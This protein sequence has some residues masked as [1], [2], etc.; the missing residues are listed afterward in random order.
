MTRLSAETLNALPQSV[1]APAYDRQAVT[2]GIVHLGIGAFHRAHMASYVD[3]C[4]PDDPRWGI[5]GVSLRSSATKNALGPQDGLYTLGVQSSQGLT[6]RII[7][8]VKDLI[9]APESPESVAERLS[10]PAIRIV[11]LTVTEKGYCHDPATGRLNA[12]HPDIA[13]DL[14]TANFPRT[15]V[16]W[17]AHGLLARK[18]ASIAPFTILSC[19]N[20]PSNGQTVRQVLADFLEHKAPD[21]VDWFASEVT[22]PSTMV[23]RI[24]PATTDEDRVAV[25]R[26]LGVQDAW[27]VITEPFTQFVVEDHFTLGRPNWEAHGVTMAED[28]EPFERMKLRMLNGS[29]STL[30]Y[31]GYLAGDETVA[32]TMADPSFKRLIG[33]LM[34]EEIK[35]T[36]SMPPEVD[37]IAYRDA[38]LERFSN[39]ALK[40]RTWQIAMD[41]SQKLPQRLLGTI[42]DRLDSGQSFDR[43]ALGVA[44]WM[45][46]ALGADE[47]GNA[48]DVRDP[49][50][51]DFAKIPSTN[52]VETVQA[53]LGIMQIFGTDLPNEPAFV[54]TVTDKFAQLQQDGARATISAHA[55]D[56]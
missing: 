44:A 54:R 36:L 51:D 24:V 28:V 7:G 48:I 18:A 40:H 22:C 13:H 31:L 2:L 42:R 49:M 29:H 32:D 4:L 16:G 56:S 23:D 11:S 43:L 15:A 12:D 17:L 33:D 45:R 50:A 38:L 26:A 21:A 47:Q 19:D 30:A 1:E 55:S 52:A 9:V 53:F 8:A 25:D 35:P 34:T 39:A 27:P 41:G 6:P 37:L 10:D 14:T 46:Y 3:A 5:C 20:L